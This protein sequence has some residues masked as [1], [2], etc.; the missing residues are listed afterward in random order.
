M[1]TA[2]WCAPPLRRGSRSCQKACSDVSATSDCN[3]KES[4]PILSNVR[5]DSSKTSDSQARSKI[6][7]PFQFELYN[8]IR[9][10]APMLPLYVDQEYILNHIL[11]DGSW[12]HHIS[13][14]WRM[15]LIFWVNFHFQ[16]CPLSFPV[17]QC[18]VAPVRWNWL[19]NPS[20]WRLSESLGAPWQNCGPREGVEIVLR[21]YLKKRSFGT[22][23]D[24][25][26]PF[27]TLN[28]EKERATK[29]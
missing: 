14:H 6:T 2:W 1:Y 4:F 7:N 5:F 25:P 8:C 26:E 15:N 24:E 20:T 10:I 16:S 23:C 17:S 9:W 11:A 22:C 28:C 21:S 29:L 18:R 13:S 3:K 19:S 27:I 12:T